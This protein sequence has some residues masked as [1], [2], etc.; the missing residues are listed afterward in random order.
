MNNEIFLKKL[1]YIIDDVDVK[2]NDEGLL[3]IDPSVSIVKTVVDYLDDYRK[4]TPY[5]NHVMWC[6]E[7]IALLSE[8]RLISP[9]TEFYDIKE[10]L[11][12]ANFLDLGGIATEPEYIFYNPE[13]ILMEYINIPSL[14]GEK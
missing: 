4:T 13:E 7:I 5:Y 6:N 8:T 10:I 11:N 12:I 14:Y 2:T 3:F 1:N 9:K